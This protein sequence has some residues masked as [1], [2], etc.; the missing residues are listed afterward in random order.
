MPSRPDEFE[1]LGLVTVKRGYS[2]L[3]QSIFDGLRERRGKFPENRRLRWE[4]GM[5]SNFE[6]P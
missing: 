6:I 2:Q 1:R 4:F 3:E 5:M